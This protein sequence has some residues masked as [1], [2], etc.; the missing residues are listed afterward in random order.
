M[1]MR[2]EPCSMEADANLNF[3][4]TERVVF[5]TSYL[6]PDA[7]FLMVIEDNVDKQATKKIKSG[8]LRAKWTDE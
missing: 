2:C 5:E 8:P 3:V 1:N 6:P 7:P 4:P